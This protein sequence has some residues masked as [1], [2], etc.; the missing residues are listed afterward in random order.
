[1]TEQLTYSYAVGPTDVALIEETI[2]INLAKTAAKY[3][4]NIALIDAAADRQWSYEQ[5][6]RDVRGL[7]TGLHRA[8]VVTGERVGIWALNRW[9]WTMVQYA[10]AEIGAIMVNIN[11]AYRQ[12][13]LN[14]V[15]QQAG[16][17][18]L[19]SSEAVPTSNYPQ[20]IQRAEDELGALDRVIIM[21][22]ASW[23]EVFD[24]EPDDAA[25]DAIQATLSNTD[26]INIQYTSGTT[27]F[28]KGATLSHRNILNNGFFVGEINRYTDQDRICIPVPYYHCFGMVMGNLAATTHGAAMVLPAQSFNAQQTLAAVEKY[29]CT[30]LYGVPT[31]FIAELALDNLADFDLSSLRTGIMA[32]SPC[33][34]EVMR[35]VIDTMN[36]DEVTI[37]YGMTETS[38][39]S[40]QTRPDD[41]L[42]LR[43]STVG[44]PSPHAEIKIV[45]PA[46]GETQPINTPGE[47]CTRGYLVMQ[48]YWNQQDKT[49]EALGEDGWMRTG[50]V[51]EMDENGYVQV[52]G[53][54]KDMVIRGG[55]NIYPRE[56]EEFLYTHPDI[57]DAQV[58]GVP[59]ERY[60]EELMAWVQLRKGAPQLTAE[61]LREFSEGSLAKYK[62]PRYVHVV[63]DFPTTVT[64]KVRKVEMRETS[65]SL[66][67]QGGVID[68]YRA[69]MTQPTSR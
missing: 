35:K 22:D 31:M 41:D 44:R 53:R 55:E 15:L 64:G 28:P 27:G 29:Q 69:P 5:F 50:D 1:M 42:K 51:A 65:L 30:S 62:I 60:G 37:C 48:G 61:G 26:P 46:T 12:H 20:L 54:M 33:P 66:L 68:D 19:I 16:I 18:T 2:S 8:G 14:Y 24:V 67:E 11:P 43:V 45:D 59:D 3:P 57:L 52:T 38:P 47:L 56:I 21:N 4:H 7:V 39:V 49:D 63:D 58:I 40:M 23:D 6:Y 13:E 34:D 32:G 17:T 10:T 25:L 9:E 36:M